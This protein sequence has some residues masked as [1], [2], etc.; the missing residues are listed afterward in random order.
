MGD[1][2]MTVPVVRA[3]VK[4]HPN[5]KI[6]FVSKA[7]LKPLFDDINNVNFYTIDV[8]NKHKGIF[9]LYKLYSELKKLE[10][11]Y[12]ADL[13]NVLRS[14]IIR[15]FFRISTKK[16]AYI[17]KGRAD[18]KALTRT[19]NK[20]FKQLKTSY[21]RY[22]DVFE[23]LGFPVDISN[24]KPIL[25]Q[26]L[27]NKVLEITGDKIQQW[28]GIA[29]FATYKPKTY[30][31]DLIEKVVEELSKKHKIFLFGG[32]EN[33]TVLESL[34]EKY[35]H[36]IS[37]ANKLGGF[38]NELNLISNLD[39]ML[40]MDSGNAHFAAIQQT[41]T[42]TLWGSTHPFAGFAPYNQPKNYCLL[43]DL[44]KHPNIPLS[45]YGNKTCKDYDD[46][47]RTILPEKIVAK[48]EEV[49]EKE[50]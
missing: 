19:N 15:L 38:K 16:T 6:T 12:I 22:A 3:F 43:P 24:P 21:Q 32:K 37:V 48:I 36:T 29:P 2:A 46:I 34:S 23:K 14:K 45:I 41:P 35:L 49:L 47:M 31:L 33:S 5:V 44:K 25:K 27:S 42:I 50:S 26:K 10:I 30:P 8:E 9:G 13:H 11:T 7:F 18:K 39:L 4:Q 40:S 17:D 1:V 28:I 20:I